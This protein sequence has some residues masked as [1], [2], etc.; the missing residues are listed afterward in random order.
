MVIEIKRMKIQ[1][2][3]K[4]NISTSD[5]SAKYRRQVHLAIDNCETVVFLS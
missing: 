2:K 3:K 1:D 5:G 4:F